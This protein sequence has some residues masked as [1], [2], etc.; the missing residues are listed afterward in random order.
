M[1]KGRDFSWWEMCVIIPREGLFPAKDLNREAEVGGQ[2]R[3]A[4]RAVLCPDSLPLP[5][6]WDLDLI[7]QPHLWGREQDGLHGRETLGARW[8]STS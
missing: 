5:L 2:G 8:Q 6:G 1:G 3:Q 7:S 4:E